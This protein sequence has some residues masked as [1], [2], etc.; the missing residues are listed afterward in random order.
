MNEFLYITKLGDWEG[1]LGVIF[2]RKMVL[3]GHHIFH[4]VHFE[5]TKLTKTIQ[6]F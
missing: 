2:L 4:S 5:L 1:H 6:G 3:E